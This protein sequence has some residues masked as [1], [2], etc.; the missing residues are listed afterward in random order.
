M[1][2]SILSAFGAELQKLGEGAPRTHTEGALDLAGLG[3]LAVPSALQL[4]ERAG[5]TSLAHEAGGGRLA[6][7]GQSLAHGVGEPIM[8]VGGLG[9][10]AAPVISHMI[11]SS[12][13]AADLAHEVEEQ[14]VMSLMQQALDLIA[15]GQNAEAGALIAQALE[16]F[17]QTEAAEGHEYERASMPGEGSPVPQEPEGMVTTASAWPAFFSELMSKSAMSPTVLGGGLGA[18]AGLAAQ[19]MWNHGSAVQDQGMLD[20]HFIT[21]E[22]HQ[23]RQ[24]VRA[25]RMGMA[26]G[27]GLAGGAALGHYAPSL[28][29]AGVA[30]AGQLAVDVARP[31]AEYA[32]EKMQGAM[33]SGADAAI[34]KAPTNLVHGLG[35]LVAPAGRRVRAALDALGVHAANLRF[36]V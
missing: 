2:S 36:P 33:T 3:V 8:E 12:K 30:G 21:P 26:G 6:R 14:G 34:R 1:H 23:Q 20:A 11:R 29:D 7:I 27:L 25:R 28:Y 32:A 4:A 10:L 16:R 15:A 9:L 35:D 22:E 17:K 24:A 13:E 5:V 31:A 19:G 18:G